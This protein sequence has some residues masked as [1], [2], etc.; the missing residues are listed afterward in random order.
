MQDGRTGGRRANTTDYI[1]PY[2]THMDQEGRMW[3]GGWGLG[4]KEEKGRRRDI[5]RKEEK[6]STVYHY[7]P[8]TQMTETDRN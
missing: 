5:R 2:V 1:D 8:V 4:Q 3:R 6:K 7:Q